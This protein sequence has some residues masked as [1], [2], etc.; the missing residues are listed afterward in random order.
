MKSTKIA[1]L[2]SLSPSQILKFSKSEAI[3]SLETLIKYHNKKYFIDNNPQISDEEFDNL[4]KL[5]K[6]LDPDN[7]ALFE[8]V[9]EIGDVVHPSP[10]LSIQKAYSF[11]DVTKWVADT[12]DN[13]YLVQP[14]YD[15]MMARYKNGQLSTRGNG[16]HGEDITERLKHLKIVGGPLL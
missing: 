14:K 2:L 3:E 5:L 8:L 11:E 7:Q 13:T 10:M 12:Y 1:S 9:G 15:G 4:T 16:I 6:E